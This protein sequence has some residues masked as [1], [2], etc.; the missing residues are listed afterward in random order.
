M[1]IIL[2]CIQSDDQHL[3]FPITL[4]VM[5]GYYRSLYSKCAK[6]RALCKYDIHSPPFRSIIISILFHKH[7]FNFCVTP[8][9]Q[10]L[11]GGLYIKNILQTA[12]TTQ[13]AFLVF[14]SLPQQLHRIII[15]LEESAAVSHESPMMK[16]AMI[17]VLQPFKMIF[18][19]FMVKPTFKLI[20]CRRFHVF[21]YRLSQNID[22]EIPSMK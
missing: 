18:L 17:N 13:I 1:M 3:N 8:Q 10:S 4:C 19:G 2:Q 9:S 21:P 6:S 15:P 20:H 16:T 14:L 22:M 12:T 5:I 11:F 7:F